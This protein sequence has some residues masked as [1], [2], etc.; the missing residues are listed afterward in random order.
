MTVASKIEQTLSKSSWIRK[1]FEEGTRLK[2]EHGSENVFDFSIGNP[3]L[4]PPDEFQSALETV[5]AQKEQWAHGYM[6]NSGF[7]FVRE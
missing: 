6:A 3:N 4:P 5:A 1:M 2:A 7:P